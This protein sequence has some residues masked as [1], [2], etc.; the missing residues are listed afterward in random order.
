MTLS[1]T[2]GPVGTRAVLKG[3]GFAAGAPM[4]LVWETS[5]AAA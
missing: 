5:S 1:P 3:E 4:R 2:Q